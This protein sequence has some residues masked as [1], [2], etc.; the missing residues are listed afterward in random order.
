LSILQTSISR[1]TDNSFAIYDCSGVPLL[2]MKSKDGK[3]A[4]LESY[5][6]DK[7]FIQDG[8]RKALTRNDPSL[9]RDPQGMHHI[10]IPV[11]FNSKRIVLISG[12]FNLEKAEFEAISAPIKSLTEI[13][14]ELNY[15]KNSHNKGYKRTKTLMDILSGIRLPTSTARV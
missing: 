8:I 2:Q 5:T 12:A 7:K 4:S 14:L 1:I 9:F 13:L 3:T 6:S 10:F 11:K 15:E